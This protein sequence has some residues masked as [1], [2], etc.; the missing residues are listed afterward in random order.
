MTPTRTVG[1]SARS[2]S[3]R[4]LALATALTLTVGGAVAGIAAPAAAAPETWTVTST[5]DVG[6]PASCADGSTITTPTAPVTLRDAVCAANNRTEATTITLQSGEYRLDRAN[7]SLLIGTTSGADITLAGPADRSAVI[8]GDGKSSVLLLDPA[9]EGDVT[10]ALEGLTITGG[11][12]GEFGGGGILAGS[13]EGGA[14][15]SLSIVNSTITGNVANSTGTATNAPG[16]G[17]QFVGGALSVVDSTISDNDSGTSSGGGIFYQT[18]GVAGERFT[19]RNSLFSGNTLS[20]EDAAAVGG[21]AIDFGAGGAA[22]GFA[23]SITDSVFEGN[24]IAGSAADR[25]AGSVAHPAR[26]A[27]ILHNSGTLEVQ[28]SRFTGNR[29]TGDA[30]ASGAAIHA[31]GGAL[32]ARFNSFTGNTGPNGT[33][34][35]DGDGVAGGVTV[36]AKNNWW[37][38]NLQA[39]QGQTCDAFSAGVVADPSLKVG[40]TATPELILLGDTTAALEVSMLKN[41]AGEPVAAS[42]L[43]LF[44]GAPVT[45]GTVLPSGASITPTAGALSAG[46]FAASYAT[47]GAK[48]PASVTATFGGADF[49]PAAVVGQFGIQQQPAF[50]SPSSASLRLGQNGSIPIASAGYPW[51]AITLDPATLPAGLTFTDAGT[52][53]ATIAGKPTAAG[54]TT[55]T[56]TSTVAGLPPVTQRLNIQVFQT[57]EFTSAAAATFQVGVSDNFAIDTQ[58]Y[59]LTALSVGGDALPTGLAISGG[60]AGAATASLA[61]TPAPGTGGLYRLTLSRSNGTDVPVTQNFMLTVNEA[62]RITSAESFELT[63]GTAGAVGF[64]TAAGYPTATSL[65]LAGALPVG[66]STVTGANGVTG[67]SGTPAA[68]TGGVYTLTLTATNGAGL[69]A[70]QTVRLVVNEA[71]HITAEPGDATVLAGSQASFTVGV[72]GYPAPSGV[73]QRSTNHGLVWT[74]LLETGPTLAITAAQSDDGSLYRYFVN[75]SA[76]SRWAQ[77][78]VGT[79]PVIGSDGTANWSVDGS[80]QE[81]E[82]FASGIPDATIT[83]TPTVPATAP[84]WLTIGAS[85]AGRL[86]IA[87][88]PPA[89]SGGVYTFAVTASN[90]FGTTAA[91]TLSITVEEAPTI[92]APASLTL[93]AGATVPAGLSVTAAGGYPVAVSLALDAASTVPPGMSVVPGTNGDSFTLGGTPST[94]GDYMLKFTA[95]NSPNGP[96]STREIPILVTVPPVFTMPSVVELAYGDSDAVPITVDPGY[97]GGEATLSEVLPYGF[98]V[99]RVAVNSWTLS[100]DLSV[101]PGVYHAF[102]NASNGSVSSGMQTI[103]ITL[104]QAPQVTVQPVSQTVTA[105]STVVFEAGASA[106]VPTTG[107]FLVTWQRSGDGVDWTDVATAPG[108]ASVTHSLTASQIMTGSYYRAV[109]SDGLSTASAAAQLTVVTPPQLTSPTSAAFE[110]GVAGSLTVTATGVPTPAITAGVLPA[111]LGFVDNGDGTA[112][113]SGTPEPGTGGS[114]SVALG[115]DNGFGTPAAMPLGVV[116]AEKPTITSADAATIAVGDAAAFTVTS[117]PGFPGAVALTRSGALPAGVTFTDNGDGTATI[118]GTAAAGSGGAYPLTLTA[119]NDSG[120]TTQAFALTVTEKPAIDSANSTEFRRG[121]AGSFTVTADGGYP[122]TPTLALAGALPSGL[123][124]V[125]AGDGTATIAGTTTDAAGDYPVTITATNGAGLAATQALTL[126]LV[127]LPAVTPPTAPPA[128]GGT[129][130]GV[131]ATA[132]PGAALD[133]SASGFA[134]DSPVVFAIYSTPTTLAT[135]TADAAGVARATITIPA[136]F[137]GRHSIVASGTSPTGAAWFVRSD[138]TVAGGSGT[139]PGTNPGANPDGGGQPAPG[140]GASGTSLSLSG[141]DGGAL[142]LGAL[143]LLVLGAAA[144]VFAA[145]RRRRRADRSV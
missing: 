108:G 23:A 78:T 132:A 131:P 26:G 24:Q 7:G 34:V 84:G 119:A 144:A 13:A 92:T 103:Q 54:D 123:A 139:D 85:A 141:F 117:G 25:V 91:S 33:A 10:V 143:G 22:A 32:T 99:Q 125:D 133:V 15:D 61:G 53:T 62:P 81:F 8:F 19:V 88:T 57:V 137:T 77:L 59:P 21:G 60:A 38:C 121:V 112:T 109:F 70:Q 107:A 27:A 67:L 101:P 75:A 11:V 100:A 20:S 65:A 64:S 6:L 129:L 3:A 71:A 96:V 106:A 122:Q 44:A 95:K 104:R 66:V 14:A 52:G 46:R 72:G 49:G 2:T 36:D 63:V 105:G 68:G 55:V 5:S 115:A 47:G 39:S 16:G 58:G 120:S 43:A 110:V 51:P 140:P 83:V 135:V 145:V 80:A 12:A 128:G 97:P 94:G 130:E 37:G 73:W 35:V 31:T 118:G 50:I 48:G 79:G 9:L 90:G 74:N 40:V 28:R 89:G 93:A 113:I 17:I 42:D 30:T 138:I 86:S 4:V 127:A 18:T 102:F 114:H 87:G 41:S 45:L 29:I 56:L 126:R 116:I 124:F 1:L 69:S 76:T 111:G 142:A 134:A 82:V 98:S 136:G